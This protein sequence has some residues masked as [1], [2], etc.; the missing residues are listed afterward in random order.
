MQKTLK[1]Y[2]KEVIKRKMKLW[3]RM[4]IPIIILVAIIFLGA[5]AYQQVENWRYLDSVYFMVVTV[6]TIGYG[7]I[8]PKT[9]IG[10][11][12]TMIFPFIGIAMAFYFLSLIGK[13]FFKK[14]LREKLHE[15]GRIKNKRG[16]RRIRPR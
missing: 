8:V 1:D 9:D 11:I 7:D 12:F 16:I 6:T 13:F 14:Q 4:L 5:Y 15:Q 10:K 2:K 3:N